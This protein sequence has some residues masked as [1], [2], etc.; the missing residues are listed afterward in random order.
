M[1]EM[2]GK[3]I[4]SVMIILMIIASF[5]QIG[6]SARPAAAQ[7]TGESEG[8]SSD[9]IEIDWENAS[10][11]EIKDKIFENPGKVFDEYPEKAKEFIRNNANWAG[12]NPK[13]AEKYLRRIQGPMPEEDKAVAEKYLTYEYAFMSELKGDVNIDGDTITSNGKEYSLSEI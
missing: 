1:I 2:T 8:E 5:G 7:D 3:R 12:A 4:T 10:E 11:D 13:V 9:E 6:I